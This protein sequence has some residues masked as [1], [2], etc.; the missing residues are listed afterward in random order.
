MQN[1]HRHQEAVMTEPR[2]MRRQRQTG[3]PASDRDLEV[4]PEV[5]N[6]LDVTDADADLIRAGCI[7]G[8]ELEAS[9][10]P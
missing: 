6:D 2:D 4:R 10:T 3:R 1:Q 9:H 7:A 8:L 5:I